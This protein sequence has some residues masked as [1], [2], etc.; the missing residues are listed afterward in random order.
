MFHRLGINVAQILIT[1]SDFSNF[2]RYKN[3][4]A[5]VSSQSMHLRVQFVF[6]NPL[7]MNP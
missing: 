7:F 5:T 2:S 1:E 3:V 6:I 4:T